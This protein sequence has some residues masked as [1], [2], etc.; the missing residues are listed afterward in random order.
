[1]REI[2]VMGIDIAKSI[3]QL[4]GVDALGRAVLKRRVS[5]KDLLR[6]V[7]SVRPTL[8]GMEACGG[9]NY[10]ARR[11]EALGCEVKL[12]P[13]QYVKPYVKTNKNDAS[14]AEA[15]C[16]AVT[17]PSMRFSTI[18]TVHQQD[19]QS[20]HRIR[21][22][23][24][25]SR[26]ALIN[27]TRGLL[28][29]YGFAIAKLPCRLIKALPEIIADERN[30]LS[31][32][33]RQTL[34][35]LQRELGTIGDLI[36]EYDRRLRQVFEENETCQRIGEIRGVG[37]LTATAV[38]AMTNDPRRYK[39][40]RH[41]AASLGLVPRQHSTGGK[42]RLLGISKRGDDYLRSLLVHGAR[43]VLFHAAKKPDRTSRWVLEKQR[44]RGHNKAC[45]ALANKNARVIWA[46]MAKGERYRVAA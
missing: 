42:E 18:K 40:G 1:M 3:F 10:W 35:A 9:A 44:T 14:D 45:V 28:L 36:G 43:A 12:M 19:V 21:C 17:R 25:K 46:V 31:A 39:N 37:P 24:V 13:P 30:E 34:G 38:Y 5:R 11:F 2:S 26:T 8:I 7:A 22:R 20:L 4:H 15:I 16:E 23:L 6:V 27:E 29:E 41:F 32:M 33:T